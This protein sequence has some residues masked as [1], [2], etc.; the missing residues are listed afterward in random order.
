MQILTSDIGFAIRDLLDGKSVEAVSSDGCETFA[1][2]I[3][4]IDDS[5]PDNPTI[6]MANGQRFIVRIVAA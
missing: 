1:F 3:D 6:V 4:F 5:D 2:P